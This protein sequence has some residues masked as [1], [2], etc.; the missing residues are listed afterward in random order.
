MYVGDFMLNNKIMFIRKDDREYESSY[1]RLKR[2][3]RKIFLKVKVENIQNDVMVLIPKY[4]NYGYILT[5]ILSYKIHRIIMYKKIKELVFEEKL[6]F[7]KKDFEQYCLST[8]KLVMKMNIMQIF[9][10]I[11]NAN[12]SNSNLENVYLLVNEYS[13]QNLYIINELI[14]SFKTVNIITENLR[15]YRR[16]EN[17]LFR[18]GVLITVSNN[19][20]KSL[21]NAK[22]VINMDFDKNRILMYNIGSKS[23]I[24]NIADETIV[25]KNG[26]NGVLIND[27]EIKISSAQDQ[28]INEFYGRIDKK[29]LLELVLKN[30][31]DKLEYIEKINQKFE[32]KI[33]GLIGVRGR[34]ENNEFLN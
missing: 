12:N 33:S 4:R 24:I 34:L 26:F 29:V 21:K 14:E 2:K 9:R 5:K 8:G 27:I 11:F 7:I 13:K 15:S 32:L 31:I 1:E 22:Y 6:D 3:I 30:N 20:R 28:F 25:L 18:E 16:L 10:Y 17:R 19:K 23:I